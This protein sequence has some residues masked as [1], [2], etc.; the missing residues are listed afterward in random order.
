[1]TALPFAA[2]R[3]LTGA[4]LFFAGTGAQ[5]E[6]EGIAVDAQLLQGWRPRAER[7]AAQRGGGGG[8]GVGRGA[9]RGAYLNI[10]APC[11]QLYTATEV[12]EVFVCHALARPQRWHQ[13]RRPS[14]PQP[15]KRPP[16]ARRADA[17]AGGSRGSR[18]PASRRE[19]R[20]DLMQLLE[21]P[22]PA[23]PHALGGELLTLGPARGARLRARASA[24]A[25]VRGEPR[26]PDRA[27]HRL[28]R[29]DHYSAAARRLCRSAWLPAAYC[30]RRGSSA[31]RL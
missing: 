24:A 18:A 27:H 2:S 15:W 20:P 21:P 31:P 30:C 26:R 23:L 19:A 11:D 12:N 4:N 1:M 14:V 13:W 22:A 9:G 25:A 17:G 28:E 6:T 8:R 16:R 7:G 5:L 10:G 3:R 29:Q